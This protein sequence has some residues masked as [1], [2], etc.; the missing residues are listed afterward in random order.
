MSNQHSPLGPIGIS[1]LLLPSLVKYISHT[2]AVQRLMKTVLDLSISLC[3]CLLLEVSLSLRGH[4]ATCR[5]GSGPK[6]Y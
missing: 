5:L 6:G 4:V 3:R 1:L 2:T